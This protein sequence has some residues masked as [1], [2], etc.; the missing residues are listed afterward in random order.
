L[1]R[2][3]HDVTVVGARWHHL[4]RDGLDTEAQH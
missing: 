2:L 3:G 4:L 1:V